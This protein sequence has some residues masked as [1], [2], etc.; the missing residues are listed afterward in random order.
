MSKLEKKRI[1]LTCS[2]LCHEKE[3]GKVWGKE[4]RNEEKG[5]RNAKE[6]EMSPL[7]REMFRD[8]IDLAL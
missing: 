7:S 2:I 4:G 6:S 8:Y 3:D 1:L 5:K